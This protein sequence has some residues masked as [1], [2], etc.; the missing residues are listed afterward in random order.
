MTPKKRIVLIVPPYSDRTAIFDRVEKVA[1]EKNKNKEIRIYPPL[2]LLYLA[3][4][5]NSLKNIEAEIIDSAALRLNFDD[6]IKVIKQGQFPEIVGISVT[7]VNL[8]AVSILIQKIR[9]EF[10][11]P[12]LVV[13]GGPHITKVPSNTFELGSDFGF[14]GDSDLSFKEFT[15][16]YLLRDSVEDI[17]G[18][19]WQRDGRIMINPLQVI[20]N[21]SALPKLPREILPIKSY[22]YPAFAGSFTSVITTRGCPFNCFYCGVPN[23][24]RYFEREIDDV[25]DELKGLKNYKYI[26]F[27]DDCFAINKKRA[28]NLCKRIIKED[29]PFR[30]GFA[31]RIECVD[32]ELMKLMRQAGCYDIRFGIESGNENIRNRIKGGKEPNN[33]ICIDVIAQAK[34]AGLR[35]V[36]FFLLGLPGET[37]QDMRE[38][39]EFSRELDLDLAYFGTVIPVPGSEL[40]EIASNE[41]KISDSVWSGMMEGKIEIPQYVPDGLTLDKIKKLCRRAYGEFYLRPSYIFGRFTYFTNFREFKHH[42]KIGFRL[43]GKC[44]KS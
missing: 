20:K 4:S 34:K 9:E 11:D 1:L 5:I 31:T 18:L 27:V 32:Y 12:P 7:S 8:Y 14:M 19:V 38:T 16:R 22:V 44:L 29:F 10:K 15:K 21:L 24:G 33:K 42:V 25:I 39:I 43:F 35:T 37:F 40:Y 28:I 23:K 36:G 17:P 6:I 2:G 13:V 41:N 3:G 30:W 26:N